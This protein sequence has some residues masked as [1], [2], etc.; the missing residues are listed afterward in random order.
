MRDRLTILGS[1]G[2][3]P[4]HGRHTACALWRRGD[5]AIMIDAGTGVGRLVEHPELLEGVA[6]LD[7]LLTHFHLDHVCGT[8]YLAA[9]GLPVQATIW[10]PGA[11]LYG[12]STRELL[13]PL[14]QEPMHPLSFDDLEVSVRDLPASELEL[15]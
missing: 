13:A 2:W 8:A 10:G 5:A 9:I 3:F 4:A 11:L 7:I 14:A 15:G 1:G 6:R 12:V